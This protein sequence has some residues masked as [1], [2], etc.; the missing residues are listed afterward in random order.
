[1]KNATQDP[2]RD[3]VLDSDAAQARAAR[4]AGATA[5]IDPHW[6]PAE[7]KQRAAHYEA[8]AR[9]FEERARVPV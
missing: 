3:L 9:R 8:E 6:T 1:M 2:Q 4:E 5:L 7:R